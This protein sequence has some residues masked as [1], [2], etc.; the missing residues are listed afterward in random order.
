VLIYLD[1]NVVNYAVEAPAGFGPR[2]KAFLTGAVARGDQLAVS[3]LTRLECR[4]SPLARGD[5][6]CARRRRRTSYRNRSCRPCF[7]AALHSCRA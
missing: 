4:V 3:D 2:A 6:E 1:T 7:I 5:A